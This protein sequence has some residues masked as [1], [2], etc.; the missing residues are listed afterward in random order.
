MILRVKGASWQRTWM[1]RFPI[2]ING[3][4]AWSEFGG[5]RCAG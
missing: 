3:S 1:V 2:D 5:F 4:R